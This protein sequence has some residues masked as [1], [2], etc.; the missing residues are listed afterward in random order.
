MVAE[1]RERRAEPRSERR[2][3]LRR[4][5]RDY[6]D[7]AVVDRQLVLQFGE[8]PDLALALGSPVAAVEAQDERELTDQLGETDGLVLVIGKLEVRE[9]ATDDEVWMH[10]MSSQPRGRASASAK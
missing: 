9:T 4:V 1:E 10:G 5:R 7:L 3:R 8:V 2:G 6:R